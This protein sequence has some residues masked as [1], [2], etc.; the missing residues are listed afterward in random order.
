MVKNWLALFFAVSL[1]VVFPG[2]VSADQLYNHLPFLR[3]TVNPPYL[4]HPDP[5]VND[6]GLEQKDYYM[7]CDICKVLKIIPDTFRQRIYRGYYPEFQ[8]IGVKRIF[9]LEQIKDIIKI[10]DSFI[11]KG[12]LSVGKPR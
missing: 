10:T 12:V 11:K 4:R 1:S 5:L 9:T 7:T 3:I 8:K 2:S 6:L